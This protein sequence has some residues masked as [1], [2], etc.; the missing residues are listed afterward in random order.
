[1]KLND[2]LQNVETA[3][4]LARKIGVTPGFVS[5]WIC[6]RR[7]IP[8]SRCI[9]IEAVTNGQVR[10]EDMRPDIQWEVL[11]K[12]GRHDFVL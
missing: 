9:Q 7:E 2:Y 8:V 1:M 6:S 3:S 12:G 10:C 4:A 11:R 5:Q